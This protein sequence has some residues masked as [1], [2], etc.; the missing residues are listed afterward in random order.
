MS[1]TTY[2]IKISPEVINGDIFVVPYSGGT[3]PV[4]SSMTQVLSGGTNGD[5]L[6]TGL[7]IQVLLLNTFDDSGYFTPFDGNLIQEDVTNSFVYSASSAN[8]YTY[9]V[10]NTSDIE[11]K[12]FL[13]NTTFFINWG[14]GSPTQPFNTF[15]P[16]VTTHNY[17]FS[18]SQY[19]ISMTGFSDWGIYLRQV[20]ITTPFTGMTIP[21]Q[22]G[23]FVFV[24]YDGNWSSDTS[25]MNFIFTGDSN[26]T[27]S[28]QTSDN[29][30]TIPFTIT[31]TSFSRLNDISQYGTNKYKLNVPVTGSS[32]SIGV[33]LGVVP[34]TT[35]TS[36]TIDN[37]FFYDYEDGTT[38]YSI[39]SSGLTF[40]ML[41]QSAI[42]KEEAYMGVVMEAEIQTNVYIERGK[43]TAFERIQRI[44]EVDNLGDLEKYGYSFFEVKTYN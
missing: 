23:N 26:N 32:G 12:K 13:G 39:S 21:N 35:I 5:S 6:L 4:Y 16:S 40:D 27:I 19:V 9:Y 24:P 29:Y 41:T 22:L 28:V 14:D 1:D 10:T 18:T 2:K 43:N 3:A 36:Y 34:N 25:N 7:T 37:V 38:I 17:P 15:S 44:A 11:R 20:T 8:P 30:T 33:F 42:T 31:G